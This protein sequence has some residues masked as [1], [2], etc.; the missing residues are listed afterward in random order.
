LVIR[1]WAPRYLMWETLK[2]SLPTNKY[3][4]VMR[5]STVR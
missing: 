1:K 5:F 2:S 3:A 4:T